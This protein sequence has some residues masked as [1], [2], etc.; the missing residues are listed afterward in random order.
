LVSS[1]NVIRSR[2][3][4]YILKRFGP[5][6][7]TTAVATVGQALEAAPA[8]SVPDHPAASPSDKPRIFLSYSRTDAAFAAEARRLIEGRGLRL[9]QDIPDMGAGAWWEQI[10]K[11]LEAPTTEH[12]V[13]LVSSTAL[14]SRVVR[15]EWRFARREGVQV[16]PVAVPGKLGKGDFATMPGWMK[17][18]HFFDWAR[19]EQK[20]R[21][22]RGLEG[23]STQ[24]RAPQMAPE[25]EAHF[26]L[27]KEEGEQLMALMLKGKSAAV[28]ITA[29][30]RGAGGYGKSQ[31]AR[32]LAHRRAVEDAFYDGILWVE[33]GE[34]PNVHDKI[35]GLIAELTGAKPGLPDLTMAA[36]RLKEVIG[37]RHILLVIDDVWGKSDLDP[38]LG[39]A[40]NLVRLVT[41]RFDHVLP[42]DAAKVPVDAMKPTEAAALLAIGLS[43]SEVESVRP[44]LTALAKRLGEWPLLLTLA[45]AQLRAEV[46]GG[47]TVADSIKYA[48]LLYDGAGLNAFDR[49]DEASRN[50]AARLSIGASLGRLDAAQGEVARFEDLALFPEDAD[51]P[52]ATVT[53]LW[54]ATGD[55]APLSGEVL[56]RTLM[57]WALLLSYDRAAGTVRLHDVVRKFLRDR[58]GS[59]GLA[60]QAKALVAAY[61]SGSAGNLTGRER[62]YYYRYL[63]QHLHEAGDRAKLDSLLMSPGWMQI[64]LA[65]TGPRNLIDDYRYAHTQGQRLTGQTLDLVGGVLAHDERQLIQQILGRLRMDLTDDPA[66]VVAVGA[67][68][69]DART[70]AD[71]PALVPRYA[72]FTAPDGPEKRRFEARGGPINAVAFSPDGQ[73]IASGSDDGT[74]R[75]W[76]VRS[77]ETRAFGGH[78]HAIAAVAFS[79]DGRNV[80]C[81]SGG[82][83]YVWDVTNG[84]LRV[85][86]GHTGAIK[87]VAFSPDGHHIVSCSDDTTLRIWEV[88]TRTSCVLKPH[89]RAHRVPVKTLAVSSD[90]CHIASGSSDGMLRVWDIESRESRTLEGHRG[91]VR[92][93]A[94][95]PNARHIISGSSDNMLRLWEVASGGSHALRGHGGTVRA[96]AFSPDG[97][98]IISASDDATLRLWELTTGDSQV[99]KGH[100]GAVRAVAFSPDG[101]QVVSGSEDQT[102]RLWQIT[103]RMSHR[104]NGQVAGVTAVAF[105]PDGRHAVFGFNHG[106][107]RLRE[108]VS[109]A[110]RVLTGHRSAVKTVAFSP[111]GHHVLSS[112]VGGALELCELASGTT[113]ALKRY[114]GTVTA[115]AFSPEGRH[116]ACISEGG[117]L[118]LWEPSS[119]TARVVDRDGPAVRAVAFSPNGRHI[120][121]GPTEGKLRLWEVATGVS[122]TLEG[123]INPGRVAAFSPDGCYVVFGS[124]SG[125]IYLWALGGASRALKGHNGVVTGVSFSAD[126]RH[127]VSGSDDRTLRLWEVASGR[128]IAR[129]EG[130]FAFLGLYLA[131]DGKSLAAGDSVGRVHLIDVLLDEADKAAWLAC[132]S[133]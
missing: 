116:V 94:F 101:R 50:S 49:G 55:L 31:L 52:A 33:L 20:E 114:G 108:L 73:H 103:S 41:T 26:V 53:R 107:V 125:A 126:G 11:V 40:P 118:R 113:C 115:V 6:K 46:E 8:T 22:L 37:D 122:V 87:A 131:P 96:V 133:G 27:R 3:L 58:V 85:L 123:H 65:A 16:S 64:K 43:R 9:W 38:F 56:L 71:P 47:A 15:D 99:L 34:H 128:E 68:I 5:K 13:L 32:W 61:A 30:L 7:H 39:G 132:R 100:A 51:I 28:G 66:E 14:A 111:N 105:A 129:L 36:S 86:D 82:K 57:K 92:A 90:G 4:D 93:V 60:L 95:S 98:H 24:V 29:A 63:P 120:L 18:Q 81:G 48:E 69:R 75:L 89:R 2:V 130:D 112:C 124:D 106:T 10:K 19:P 76:E 70:L 45:N 12:M 127:L 80:V 83:L 104:L 17:A 67:L 88:V 110:S 62:L 117:Y 97:D 1:G 109:G 102:V 72:S 79:P 74:L 77:G 84:S 121:S 25:P 78:R 21:L 54:H 91:P 23:P 119:G 42:P 35:E 44:A 59:Y